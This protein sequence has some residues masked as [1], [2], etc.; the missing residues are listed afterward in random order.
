MADMTCPTGRG[1]GYTQHAAGNDGVWYDG[2]GILIEE[3]A[4]AT[5]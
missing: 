5:G 4:V 3:D 1:T 2:T